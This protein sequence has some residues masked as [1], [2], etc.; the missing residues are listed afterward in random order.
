MRYG[1]ISVKVIGEV[2]MTGRKQNTVCPPQKK[3]PW[4]KDYFELVIFKAQQMQQET[5]GSNGFVRDIEIYN[6][7]L[8]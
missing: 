2:S 6:E 7:N 5:G 3:P 8:H 1:A 4:H